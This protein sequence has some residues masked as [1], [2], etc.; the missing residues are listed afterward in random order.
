M[1]VIHCDR[2]LFLS[3]LRMSFDQTVHN[4]QLAC[5][6]ANFVV[7]SLAQLAETPPQSPE[8]IN[9]DMICPSAASEE[10]ANPEHPDEAML[11][12]DHDAFIVRLA[13][14]VKCHMP[15]GQRNS[16]TGSDVDGLAEAEGNLVPEAEPSSGS[17][18]HPKKKPKDFA[19][20]QRAW[21]RL[22]GKFKPRSKKWQQLADAMSCGR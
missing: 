12:E 6:M 16:Q 20:S 3:L 5:F 7:D 10:Q 4:S 11:P 14:A 13:E 9:P 2:M 21:E 18:E 17:H 1:S 8:Q 22:H 15:Q 19:G